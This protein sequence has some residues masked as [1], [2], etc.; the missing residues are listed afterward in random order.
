M[1]NKLLL[2]LTAFSSLAFAGPIVNGTLHSNLAAGTTTMD[3]IYFNV[4]TPG[5]VTIDMLAW[6]L[7]SEDRATADGISEP[8]DLNG[9]GEI[10]VLDTHIFLFL[11]DGL[12]DPGDYIAND[13]DDFTNT[14][15]DG[16]IYGYDSYLSLPLAAGSYVLVVSPCCIDTSL[17]VGGVY[18]YNAATYNQNFDPIDHA[19]YRATF[20]GD[21]TVTG[22]VPEPGTLAMLA[23]PL[24]GVWLAR[25]RRIAKAA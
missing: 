1:T 15:G 3:R 5:V 14:Y 10:T 21:V 22:A 9:D 25:R 2:C 11:N 7:D 19:D 17:A 24:A 23:L 18:P 13:D 16:S 6:E 4:N 8:V 12:L 20:T